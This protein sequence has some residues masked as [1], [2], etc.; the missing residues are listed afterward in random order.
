M[1]RCHAA[2]HFYAQYGIWHTL[3]GRIRTLASEQITLYQRRCLLQWKAC[4]TAVI[5]KVKASWPDVPIVFRK[6]HR[7]GDNLNP[8]YDYGGFTNFFT[9]VRVQQMRA[10]QHAVAEEEGLAT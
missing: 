4:T 3:E 5:R 1:S 7:I 6:M 9:A 8:S 10:L 2:K